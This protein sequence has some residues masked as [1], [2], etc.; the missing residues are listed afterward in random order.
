MSVRTARRQGR[1]LDIWPGFVDALAALLII[2]IFVL[3]VFM[4]AQ[5]YLNET[6]SSRDTALERLNSRINELV[7]LLVVEQQTADDLR[8]TLT[9]LSADLQASE[10]TKEDL[11][12][13]I[14]EAE[15][16]LEDRD[17]NIREIESSLEESGELLLA[18]QELSEKAKLEVVLLN[19]QLAALRRQLSRLEA[20][21]DVAESKAE[22]QKIEIADLGQRLNLALAARV[23]ELAKYRS[24]FFGRLREVIGERDDIRIVGDRFVFQSEVLFPSGSAELEPE[25]KVQLARLANALVEIA[26]EIPDDLDWNL[27]I[28]GHTDTR[29][30]STAAFPSNWELSQARALSVV[31]FLAEQ[32][33]DENRLV[34]AGFGEF[35]PLV[36]GDSAAALARNRRIELKFDQR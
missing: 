11:L 25:G 13:A 6:L 22:E 1:I 5:F 34:A 26:A 24:E 12:A 36:D 3:M 31:R 17:K 10:T 33:I 27:R 35:H 21:L 8:S 32:G 15:S 2:I 14:A 29:P 9:G 19:R 28:D 30:I 23:E 4:V 16:D 20:A 18:E 7:D